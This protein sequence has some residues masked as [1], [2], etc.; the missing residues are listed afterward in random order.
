MKKEQTEIYMQL[1]I[2]YGIIY[3]KNGK[4]YSCC[5]MDEEITRELK[6]IFEE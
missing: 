1:F 4:Y 3:K 2:D 6:C 5:A